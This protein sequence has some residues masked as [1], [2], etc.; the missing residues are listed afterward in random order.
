MGDM[1]IYKPIYLYP[2]WSLSAWCEFSFL[3]YTL[4]TLNYTHN[5]HYTLM[6][7]SND[8]YALIS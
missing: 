4:N 5:T 3:T 1:F 7:Y 8:T 6:E 2:Y